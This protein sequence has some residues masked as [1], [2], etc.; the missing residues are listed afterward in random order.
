MLV[1]ALKKGAD[2]YQDVHGVTFEGLLTSFDLMIVQMLDLLSHPFNGIT[3]GD[4]IDWCR[5]LSEPQ[6]L[7]VRR[8][9]ALQSISVTLR[10]FYDQPIVVLIDEYDSPMHTAIENGYA[11]LVLPLVII[12]FSG[13]LTF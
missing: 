8:G 7:Q 4:F 5:W 2:Q 1:S 6:N 3:D 11:P 12:P 10:R 13:S 9:R